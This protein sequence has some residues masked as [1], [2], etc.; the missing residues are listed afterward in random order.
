MHVH[1]HPTPAL[2]L[3]TLPAGTRGA[4]TLARERAHQIGRNFRAPHHTASVAAIGSEVAIAAGGVLYLDEPEE[5]SRPAAHMIY[6]TVKA[7]HPDARPV[8]ILAI[9]EAGDGIPL[10]ARDQ[11]RR[12]ERLAQLYGGW[13]V[14]VHTV[15]GAR[16]EQTAN[17]AS[18]A[19]PIPKNAGMDRNEAI[20]RIKAALQRRSGKT[21]GV[22]GGRGTAWGWITVQAPPRRRTSNFDGTASGDHTTPEERAELATL[23]GL[24]RIHPQGCSIAASSHYYREY[25]DRAEGRE[26]SVRGEPYWD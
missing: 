21:W 22:T 2:E 23:L 25:V 13:R 16:V 24:E 8:V 17:P 14:S 7:M 26:P 9:R 11:E 19:P 12:V 4:T 5:I 10:D 18:G 1:E 3:I 6:S 15:I 20:K